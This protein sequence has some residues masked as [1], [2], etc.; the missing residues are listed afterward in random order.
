MGCFAQPS[1]GFPITRDQASKKKGAAAK[2]R[3]AQG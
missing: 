2:S 3:C 1:S